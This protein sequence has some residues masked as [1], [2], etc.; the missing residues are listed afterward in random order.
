M[1][2]LVLVGVFFELALLTIGLT[3]IR[4][5]S[6]QGTHAEAATSAASTTE[7]RIEGDGTG[8]V[9]EVNLVAESTV[10][11]IAPGVKFQAWTF[12]GTAPG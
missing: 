4:P 3:W 10:Q 12:N 6:S 2:R 7:Y 1:R 11:E 9:V 8:N 5:L